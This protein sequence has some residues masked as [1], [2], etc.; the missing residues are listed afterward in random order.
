MYLYR[1]T[2]NINKKIY[3]GITN[4][5]KKRWSNH[6]LEDT[7]ISKAIKKYGKENFTFEVLFDNVPIEQID[8]LE[9]EQIKLHN[10]LVPNGYNVSKG[11]QYFYRIGEPAYGSDNNNAK[12]TYEEVKY[13]KNHRNEPVYLLYELFNEKITYAAFL[14]IYHHK[15]YLNI[16]PTV[17]EYPYNSEFTGQ[18]ATTAKLTYED[19][20]EVREQYKQG[21]YWKVAYQKYKDLYPHEWDFWN[22]YY[23]NRYK[24]VMPE[25]F[26]P[27]N[28]KIHSSLG[29]SGEKNGRAKL[30]I[31]DIKNIRALHEKGI[32]NSE[33]YVLYPQVTKTSIRDIINRKTWKN[34]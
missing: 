25:V 33:I 19:V 30:K 8:K 7:V 5:Y 2:N 23:G 13:I 31:E 27:E 14:K 17:P 9:I 12:L 21:I 4:N 26:T 15:T 32:P 22:I 28:K 16:E 18:F 34:V 10:S 3:I 20:C 6:G 29:K 1:I 24:L 11:G